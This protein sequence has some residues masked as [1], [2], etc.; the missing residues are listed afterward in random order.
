MSIFAPETSLDPLAYKIQISP[1]PLLGCHLNFYVYSGPEENL[2]SVIQLTH[3]P[4]QALG[5]RSV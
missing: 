5:L 2:L 1:D 4:T 3:E